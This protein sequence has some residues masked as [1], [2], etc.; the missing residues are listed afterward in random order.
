MRRS[1]NVRTTA[2]SFLTWQGHYQ[3][4]QQLEAKLVAVVH[5]TSVQ[6]QASPSSTQCGFFA[7]LFLWANEI[8]CVE[9]TEKLSIAGATESDILCSNCNVGSEVPP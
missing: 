4:Q 1:R 2:T 9:L 7:E 3:S 6:E 8:K 5:R